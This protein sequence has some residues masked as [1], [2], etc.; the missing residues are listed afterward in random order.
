M[1]SEKRAVRTKLELNTQRKIIANNL[2]TRSFDMPLLLLPPGTSCLDLLM[3][4]Q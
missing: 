1:T 3:H 4:Q 2:I